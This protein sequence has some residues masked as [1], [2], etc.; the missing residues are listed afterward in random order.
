M[1]FKLNSKELIFMPEV[2]GRQSALKSEGTDSKMRKS[3]DIC[4]HN[5]LKFCDTESVF[6]DFEGPLNTMIYT[7]K[8][9]I[10]RLRN[11]FKVGGQNIRELKVRPM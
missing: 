11:E 6:P 8:F 9:V 5:F 4:F 7:I 1:Q 3:G 10:Q 2:Q